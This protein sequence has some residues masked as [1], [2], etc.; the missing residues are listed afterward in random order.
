MCTRHQH[1][2]PNTLGAA[3]LVTLATLGLATASGTALHT[4]AIDFNYIVH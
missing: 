3:F 4:S 2:L 1:N